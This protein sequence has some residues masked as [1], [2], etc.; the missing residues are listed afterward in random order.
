MGPEHESY[1]TFFEGWDQLGCLR[2]RS[3]VSCLFYEWN[4]SKG[5]SAVTK[6]G[7]VPV[8]R[9]VWLRREERGAR[10]HF[11]MPSERLA[12][13]RAKEAAAD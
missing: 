6:I 9:R 8:T 11:G 2:V 3:A 13:T 10:Q 4:T 1:L 7:G 12:A 5:S